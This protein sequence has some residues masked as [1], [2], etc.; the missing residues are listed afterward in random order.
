IDA[1]ILLLSEPKLA[2][3][4]EVVAWNVVPTVYRRSFAEALAAATGSQLAVHVKVDTGMHRV[5]ADPA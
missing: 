5:G 4:A 2:E 3:A 1:E